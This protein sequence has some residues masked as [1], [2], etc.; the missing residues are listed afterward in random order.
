MMQAKCTLLKISIFEIMAIHETQ[1]RIFQPTI[2]A[3]TNVHV[4]VYLP[5]TRSNR[6]TQD[7]VKFEGQCVRVNISSVQAATWGN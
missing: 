5:L 2:L 7:C 4:P 3:K 6:V 1:S